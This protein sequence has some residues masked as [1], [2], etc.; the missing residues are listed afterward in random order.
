LAQ[1]DA[2]ALVIYGGGGHGK[3]LID[4]VRTA[5]VYIP[6][7]VVDDGLPSG[8]ELLGVPILGGGEVLAGL[9]ARGARCAV[10]AVGGIGNLT[11]R[12]KVF[13]R[14]AH[15]GF[16]CPAV[17][18]PAAVIE[19]SANLADGV[20]VF[21]LAYVGSSARVG[22]GCIVNTGVILSHDVVMG[23]YSNVSPGAMLAG[24][25][26]VGERVLIGMGVTIN[27]E[28]KIGSGARIGNGAT[29]KADVPPGGVVHAGTIWPIR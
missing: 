13:E 20:Q 16:N 29:V 8:G 19:P 24:A 4:L 15:E 22:F 5:D 11:P 17:V 7:C 3:S 25:V 14:L 6:V 2:S 12:L 1:Y 27:L 23:A 9:Y 10:N 18:H 28:V 26:Q 21:A